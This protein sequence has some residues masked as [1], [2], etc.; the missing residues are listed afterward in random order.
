ME[1]NIPFEDINNS[2]ECKITKRYIKNEY[3][4]IKDFH[5]K[6]ATDYYYAITI[7]FDP[8]EF[9]SM[10][11][12]VYVSWF[13][14]CEKSEGALSFA[15]FFSDTPEYGNKHSAPE[16]LSDLLTR[17]RKELDARLKYFHEFIVPEDKKL[18]AKFIAWD[19][20]CIDV[21]KVGVDPHETIMKYLKGDK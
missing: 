15:T 1:S 11:E 13:I 7:L 3:P 18:K 16:W 10:H 9:A 2:F 20:K 5:V 19:W 17:Y 8:W 12:G 14:D 4:F 21:N 6:H